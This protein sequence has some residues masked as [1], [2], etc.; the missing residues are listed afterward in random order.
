MPSLKLS[1]PFRRSADRPS[2]KERAASLR[3]TAS[4]VMSRKPA[5]P[6][7]GTSCPPGFVPYPFDRP[8]SYA[9]VPAVIH[10]E[11]TRLLD[12]AR[13]EYAR[14]DASLASR[15]GGEEGE[16]IRQAARTALRLDA[17]A[18]AAAPSQSA[19]APNPDAELL[20][21]G[22]RWRTAR[23]AY[24][25]ASERIGQI[26]EACRVAPPNALYVRAGD[27][28]LGIAQFAHWQSGDER[29][30]Y[31]RAASDTPYR[32]GLEP[33]TGCFRH[34]QIRTVRRP[35]VQARLDEV[36]A[37]YDQ[38]KREVA[39][40]KAAS[41]LVQAEAEASR[42]F[43]AECAL[44]VAALSLTAFSLAGL[45]IQ[46]KIALANEDH[47]EGRGM[48]WAVVRNLLTVA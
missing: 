23:A 1:N 13:T 2:L 29:E 8:M 17:L 21:L 30:W 5:D 40:A 19:A 26:E 42:L 10:A 48:A 6:L 31:W 15:M 32:A 47:Q 4:R 39:Q 24:E 41:G 45:R 33:G 35:A 27:A 25:A 34:G 18:V 14:R 43:A 37:A 3:A 11:T 9:S 38:H 16:A 36:C 12:L 7:D 46:A 22:C 44:E 20:A 28:A